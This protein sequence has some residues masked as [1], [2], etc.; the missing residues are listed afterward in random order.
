MES[1]ILQSCLE[2]EAGDWRVIK[3]LAGSEKLQAR[4]GH[5]GQSGKQNEF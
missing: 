3:T 2:G 5:S 1:K 4:S